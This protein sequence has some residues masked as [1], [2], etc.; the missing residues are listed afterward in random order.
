MDA[1][2]VKA[3][4][5][6][7]DA[8][9]HMRNY[10]LHIVGTPTGKFYFVGNVPCALGFVSKDGEPVSDQFVQDQLLLPSAARSIKTR[11]FD[12]FQ[13]AQDAANELGIRTSN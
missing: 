9:K 8:V 4:F 12:S 10:G 13:E 11:V 5:A 7:Q 6:A 3:M 2:Q 1:K